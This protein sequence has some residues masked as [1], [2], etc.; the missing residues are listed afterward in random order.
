MLR[1][2]LDAPVPGKRQRVRQTARWKD[3]C[4]GDMESVGLKEEDARERTKWKNHIQFH[5]SDPRLWE[6]PKE[7]KLL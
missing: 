6:K 4:K 2:M 1:R 3:L 5:S 7:E